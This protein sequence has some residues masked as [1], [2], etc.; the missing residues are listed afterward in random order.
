MCEES[1]SLNAQSD[2]QRFAQEMP[3]RFLVLIVATMRCT[4]NMNFSATNVLV[5]S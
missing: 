4:F 3:S 1:L 2:A 5:I